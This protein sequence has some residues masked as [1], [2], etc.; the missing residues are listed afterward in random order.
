[1]L[2]CIITFEPVAQNR[3]KMAVIQVNVI[4]FIFWNAVERAH[5]KKW[6]TIL[7][8]MDWLYIQIAVVI[9]VYLYGR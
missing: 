4:F 5:Y 9:R 8:F 1:M 2:L 3:W 6:V 7:V